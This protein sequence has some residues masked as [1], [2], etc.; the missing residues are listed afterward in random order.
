MNA[1][2][3]VALDIIPDPENNQVFFFQQPSAENDTSDVA[4]VQAVDIDE[5]E[6]EI[7]L[8]LDFNDYYDTDDDDEE[9]YEEDYEDEDEI[10]QAVNI[11][12]C[13]AA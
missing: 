6:L 1:S 5:D 11:D 3:F 9:E 12:P 8:G 10:V 2:K 7:E 13:P 4:D